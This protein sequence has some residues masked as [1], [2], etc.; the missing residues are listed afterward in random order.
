LKALALIALC[1]WAAYSWRLA[2]G[3]ALVSLL[4][5]MFYAGALK[6]SADEKMARVFSILVLTLSLL[7]VGVAGERQDGGEIKYCSGVQ[8]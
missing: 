3:L 8:C 6:G 7:M 2:A 5:A 4:V 1:A